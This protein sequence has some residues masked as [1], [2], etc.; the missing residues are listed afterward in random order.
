[1]SFRDI[2]VPMLS[3]GSDMPALKVA[4]GVAQI[5]DAT[6]TA[7][8]LEVQPDPLYGPE[9]VSLGSL[10]SDY[11]VRLQQQFEEDKARLE[12]RSSSKPLDVRQLLVTP[13]QTD[14]LLGVASRAADLVVMLARGEPWQQDLRTSMIEGALFGSGRPILL[15]PPSW[16]RAEVGKNIMVAWNGK[17]EAA[18][19]LG[20]A[21]PLLQ[22]AQKVSLVA[23]DNLEELTLAP[24][25]A[26]AHLRRKGVKAEIH[27]LK[28]NQSDAET[29]LGAASTLGADLIV[30]GGYGRARVSEMV[31]GGVTR[32]LIHDTPIPLLMSH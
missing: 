3:V 11:L 19:A 28:R 10:L 16:P 15:V 27:A 26:A 24:E 2:L 12:D 20:D 9:G 23:V 8:L 22:H 17:R 4:E 21:E 32:S 6:L 5:A 31:F 30:M 13:G 29:L 18:R 1:M 25:D 14:N 7:T